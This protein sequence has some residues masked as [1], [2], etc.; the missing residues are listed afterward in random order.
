[1]LGGLAAGLGLAW[2]ASALGFGEAFGQILMFG[3]LA[4]LA[5]GVIGLVAVLGMMSPMM[6]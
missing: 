6:M 1:M 5:V 2:L 4:M 3:L